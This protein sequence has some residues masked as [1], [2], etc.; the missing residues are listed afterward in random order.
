MSQ[1]SPP[2]SIFLSF[3]NTQ[4]RI[5]AYFLN[6]ELSYTIM[7]GSD[8]I[9]VRYK[10]YPDVNSFATAIRDE[11]PVKIDIGAIYPCPVSF[12]GVFLFEFHI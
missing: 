1:N 9:Y 6:R 12:F 5:A 3:E 11:S 10:S 7:A 4:Q 2:K 8:E